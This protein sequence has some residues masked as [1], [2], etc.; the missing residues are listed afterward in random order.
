MERNLLKPIYE[1]RCNGR[2]QTKRFTRLT[3]CWRKGGTPAPRRR[4]APTPYPAFLLPGLK[5]YHILA[6]FLEPP[7]VKMFFSPLPAEDLKLIPHKEVHKVGRITP[8]GIQ[9]STEGA[10]SSLSSSSA[11]VFVRDRR[12]ISLL[13]YDEAPNNNCLS[14]PQLSFSALPLSF[15]LTAYHLPS[16]P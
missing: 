4:P 10:I 6:S 2:L 3:H 14:P 12:Q 15:D 7:V 8:S 16:E 11:P 9:S 1:C 13:V 5:T